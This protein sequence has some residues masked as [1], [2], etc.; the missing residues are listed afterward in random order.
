MRKGQKAPAPAP[1]APAQPL[2][3]KLG[4]LAT[5]VTIQISSPP[6]RP[7]GKAFD[8]SSLRPERVPLYE[9]N[10]ALLI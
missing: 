7:T 8:S 2:P 6:I 9:R 4:L 10:C 3:L 1:A 5:T